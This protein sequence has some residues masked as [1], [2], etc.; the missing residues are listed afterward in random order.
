MAITAE[1]IN[2]ESQLIIQTLA[3]RTDSFRPLVQNYWDRAFQIILKFV[4]NEETA[5]DICQETFITAFSKLRQ[6][7]TESRFSPWLFKIASNKALE[8][9]RSSKNKKEISFELTDLPDFT[10]SPATQLHQKEFLDACIDRLPE[11]HQILFVLR[12][13]MEFSYD[14]MA[15]ILDIPVGTVKVALFRIRNLLKEHF[16]SKANQEQTLQQGG[17][18]ETN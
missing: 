18:N 11:D 12:H 9:L 3:G 10:A 5:A 13:G 6:F 17:T 14:D 8:Y 16:Y 2:Y 7:K 15:Y 1:E 4:K